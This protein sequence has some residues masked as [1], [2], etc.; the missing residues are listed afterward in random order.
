MKNPADKIRNEG[1]LSTHELAQWLLS[2]PEVA[3]GPLGGPEEPWNAVVDSGSTLVEVRV[4][5]E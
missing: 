3:L 5:L 4:D 1:A 2:Q